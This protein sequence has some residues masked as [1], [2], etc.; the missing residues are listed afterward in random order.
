M[1]CV[2]LAQKIKK[3]LDDHNRIF[4]QKIEFGISITKGEIIAKSEK[5]SF[6]FM[7][8]GAIINTS[9]KI[10]TASNEEILL[11]EKTKEKM[12]REIR[13]E[14]SEINKLPIYKIIEIKKLEDN[15]KFLDSFVERM[16]T[17]KRR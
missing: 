17:E 4:K 14:K 11:D 1:L 2:E 8:L 16:K 9:K 12:P 7:S 15:K 13:T 10:A 5:S 6:Q 3:I